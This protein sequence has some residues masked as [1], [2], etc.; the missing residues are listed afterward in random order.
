ML[1]AELD[2]KVQFVYEIAFAR[3]ELDGL[4]VKYEIKL[5]DTIRFEIKQPYNL[6][7]LVKRLAHFERIDQNAT[8][9][10]SKHSI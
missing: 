3:R 4:G 7:Y 1:Q 6:D 5:K 8:E 9:Y 2:K 10:T